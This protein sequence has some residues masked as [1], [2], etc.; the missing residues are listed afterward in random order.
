MPFD[1][2]AFLSNTIWQ[3]KKEFSLVL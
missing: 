3:P 2:W 1:K